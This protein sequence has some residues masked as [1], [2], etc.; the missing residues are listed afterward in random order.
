MACDRV[1]LDTDAHKM[2]DYRTT[3]CLAVIQL[4]VKPEFLMLVTRTASCIL[5]FLAYSVNQYV[6]R[7]TSKTSKQDYCLLRESKNTQFTQEFLTLYKVAWPSVIRT[8]V[9]SRK[10]DQITSNTCDG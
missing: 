4:P 8:G 5:V 7:L 10:K 6:E 2:A 3:L 9:Q 1:F